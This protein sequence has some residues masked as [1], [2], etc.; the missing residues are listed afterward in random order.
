MRYRLGVHIPLRWAVVLGACVLA[1]GL[2]VCA[3]LD[4][5]PEWVVAVTE[6]FLASGT[7]YLALQARNEAQAVSHEATAVAKQADLQRE[8][9]DVGLRAIVIPV[10]PVDWFDYDPLPKGI[11]AVKGSVP[12]PNWTEVLRIKNV[13]PSV[14]LNI[15]GR[16]QFPPPTGVFVDFE[17]V[18]LG[19]GEDELVNINP[20]KGDRTD[21]H[22]VTGYVDYSDSTTAHWR[23]TFI[24]ETDKTLSHEGFPKR[25]VLGPITFLYRD[26]DLP[27]EAEH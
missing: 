7:V 17:L 18:A 22:D 6:I 5:A 4:V 25:I 2:A 1:G 23:S 26:R 27:S 19:P 9:I 14:A 13:G 8:A 12:H 11:P 3:V 21:W 16:L 15:S 10:P 20:D 24:V